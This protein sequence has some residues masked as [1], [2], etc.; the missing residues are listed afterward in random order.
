M[1]WLT[2][3]EHFFLVSPIKTLLTLFRMGIFGVPGPG[4]GGGGGF[5]SPSPLH[6]SESIDAIVMKLGG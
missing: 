2:I 1:I 3:V 4:G 6:K 5:K